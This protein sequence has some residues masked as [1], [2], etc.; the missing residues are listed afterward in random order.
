MLADDNEDVRQ[1]KELAHQIQ[2][3]EE[4]VNNDDCPMH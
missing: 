4:R 1:A 2:V 3:A